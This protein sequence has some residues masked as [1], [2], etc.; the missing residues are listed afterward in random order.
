MGNVQS[1]KTQNFVGLINKAVDVGYRFIIVIGSINDNNLRRQTQ[2]RVDSGFTGIDTS[3]LPK[4]IKNRLGKNRG[5]DVFSLTSVNY[6]FNK[7]FY[8]NV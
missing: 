4:I 5:K 3:L 8:A 1:G 7:S 6:D 2:L